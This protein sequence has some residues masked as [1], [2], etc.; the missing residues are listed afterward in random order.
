MYF[1]KATFSHHMAVTT[2]ATIILFGPQG[3]TTFLPFPLPCKP[4]T[5]N[6]LYHNTLHY[7]IAITY[8]SFDFIESPTARLTTFDHFA[9]LWV[10]VTLFLSFSYA[11]IILFLVLRTPS[12]LHR[13]YIILPFL[14]GPSNFFSSLLRYYATT[15]T[16]VTFNPYTFHLGT[17]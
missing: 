6:S 7:P 2:I 14:F 1:S 16:W 8:L 13:P 9:F 12:P 4:H 10:H 5:N 15:F 3:F 11:A 17:M